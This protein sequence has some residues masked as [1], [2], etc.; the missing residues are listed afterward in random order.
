MKQDYAILRIKGSSRNVRGLE[1]APIAGP[2]A[3]ARGEGEDVELLFDRLDDHQRQRLLD[4]RQVAVVAP[5]MPMKLIEPVA[6]KAAAMPSDLAGGPAAAAT[7]LAASWGVAAVQANRAGAPTGS[8]VVVAVLDT[9]IDTAHPAFNGVMLVGRNFTKGSATAFQDTDGHGTHCA[10]TIFGR[11]VQGT[12]IGIA[13][14]VTKAIIG[15][16][17]GPG[18]GSSAQIAEAVNWAISEGAHV[19]SMSLGI[20]F[21]GYIEQ[22]QEQDI[23]TVAAISLGLSGYRENLRLFDHL[24]EFVGVS[25]KPTLLIAAAGNESQRGG[26]PSYELDVAPPAVA[27]GFISVAALEPGPHG[28]RAA[29]FSN[30]GAEVAA[31]G[32]DILSAAPGGGLALMSGTSMATPHVAGIAALWAE[33]LRGQ[34]LFRPPHFRTKVAGSAT[35]AGIDPS[36]GP[37]EVGAGIVQAP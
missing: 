8:G 29:S 5:A 10:G 7:A 36:V 24:A 3:S 14:G 16:V 32:V 1:G 20:D 11:D 37:G 18:G 17:I 26:N 33:Q 2:R 9:G 21:P 22:L 12:R 23:P 35:M 6:R 15:K 28:M 27:D 34:N 13:R 30:S 31:P 4:D 25:G 19:I